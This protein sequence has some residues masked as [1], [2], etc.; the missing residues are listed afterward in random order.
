[1]FR[2]LPLDLV[3]LRVRLCRR[4]WGEALPRRCVE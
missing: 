1:M 2:L 4:M 3:K